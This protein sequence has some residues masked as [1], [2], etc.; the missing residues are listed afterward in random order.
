MPVHLALPGKSDEGPAD[1]ILE[2]LVFKALGT[3]ISAYAA[4]RGHCTAS[5]SVH[6]TSLPPLHPPPQMPPPTRNLL[7][8]QGTA[9]RY[10]QLGQVRHRINGL[11]LHGG[12]FAPH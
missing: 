11:N 6:S 2:T 1:H 9:L 10:K 8:A 5:A 12:Q 4:P 3:D 7:A